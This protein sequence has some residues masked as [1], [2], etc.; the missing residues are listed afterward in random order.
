MTLVGT[1]EKLSEKDVHSINAMSSVHPRKTYCH[2]GE[3][4][5]RMEKEEK[6]QVQKRRPTQVEP[7][8][9]TEG[10]QFIL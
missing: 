10:Q 4:R 9:N 1:I 2:E 8:E 3:R 7:W 5:R 6:V